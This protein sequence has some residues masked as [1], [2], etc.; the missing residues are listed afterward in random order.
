MDERTTPPDAA[1]V[2]HAQSGVPDASIPAPGVAAPDA[3]PA[4][5]GEPQGRGFPGFPAGDPDQL[6]LS[7]RPRGLDAVPPLGGRDPG[8][9]ATLARERPYMR[10]L[11]GMVAVIVGG[12]LLLTFLALLSAAFLR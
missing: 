3:A 6:P 8:I 12:S 10:L 5:E 4:P 7:Q 9:R 11:V 1:T 2:A